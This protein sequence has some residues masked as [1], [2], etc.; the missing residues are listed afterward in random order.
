MSHLEEL[1]M[2]VKGHFMCQCPLN[3]ALHVFALKRQPA[4]EHEIKHS[5]CTKAVNLDTM[6]LVAKDFRSCIARRSTAF[7]HCFLS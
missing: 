5:A 2:I 1:R 3:D 7:D 4:T 6:M